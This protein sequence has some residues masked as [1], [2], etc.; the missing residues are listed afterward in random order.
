ML[1]V[2]SSPLQHKVLVCRQSGQGRQG[3]RGQACRKGGAEGANSGS[4]ADQACRCRR[5]ADHRAATPDAALP[6]QQAQGVRAHVRGGVPGG[7]ADQPAGVTGWQGQHCRRSSIKGR[8]WPCGKSRRPSWSRP[9]AA[10]R[11]FRG[12]VPGSS[13]L[14]E[15]RSRRWQR[16]ALV[17]EVRLPTSLL[18]HPSAGSDTRLA[19]QISSVV[20]HACWR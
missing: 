8:R 2:L 6:A 11:R 17:E 16:G 15:E 3:S 14:G 19:Q 12:G 5:E 13:S 1:M 4:H 9:G 10:K 7:R 18:A 20:L